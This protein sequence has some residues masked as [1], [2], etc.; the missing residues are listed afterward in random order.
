MGERTTQLANRFREVIFDGQWVARTNYK[1][2]L[3]TISWQ[4]ATMAIPP[5]HTIAELTYHICYY[6]QGV[7]D[8]LEHGT[9][10]IKDQYS[11]EAVPIAS[12]AAWETQLVALWEQSE[13][14]ATLV[15][16]L[17]DAQL[18]QVFV[19]EA[20]GDYQR[21]I[22]GMIEHC[23]YHLGQVVWMKKMLAAQNV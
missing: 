23:Y 8:F 1:A 14:F 5:L 15:A 7:A 4:E 9:L 17:P 21:N 3:R 18:D 12:A 16:A 13:R 11:F 22:D 19:K 6:I 20:Y 2:Q 10:T